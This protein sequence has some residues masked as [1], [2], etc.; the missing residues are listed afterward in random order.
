MIQALP[1]LMLAFVFRLALPEGPEQATWL[2]PDEKAWLVEQLAAERQTRE[3]VQRFSVMGALT[4]PIIWA[5]AIAGTGINMAAYG[6]ILFLPLMINALGVSSAMTPLVNAIPFAVAAVVMVFWSIHS[7]LKWSAT[8]M[9][10][11]RPLAQVSR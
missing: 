8:G 7:D 2:P 5:I 4:S 3:S 6:L 9:P 10:R 11:S 1:T